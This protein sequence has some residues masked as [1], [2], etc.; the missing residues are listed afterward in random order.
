MA[1][2]DPDY[3]NWLRQQPCN[4]CGSQRGCDPHH[5]TG[6]GMAMR[7]HDH[8]AMPMCRGCHTQFHAGSGFFKSLDRQGKGDYQ[9]EAIE[10]CRRVY[11]SSKGPAG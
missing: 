1:G 11:M 2:E 10:R 8:K 6:A 5:R 9:D 4:Q 3:T 7:S